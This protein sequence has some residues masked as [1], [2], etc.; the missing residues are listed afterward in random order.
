MTEAIV[1]EDKSFVVH[2]DVEGKFIADLA[3]D[4]VSEGAWVSALSLL[5]ESFEGLTHEEAVAILKGESDLTGWNSDEAGIRIV[6]LG[7]DSEAALTMRERLD[8]LYG[9]VFKHDGTYWKPYATVTSWG[10][11]D[12]YFSLTYGGKRNILDTTSRSNSSRHRPELEHRSLYYAQDPHRDLL[13]VL[14]VLN[15]ECREVLCERVDMPPLWFDVPQRDIADYLA[16]RLKS[17]KLR[18][19][20]EGYVYRE[21]GTEYRTENPTEEQPHPE[22]LPA[23]EET[24]GTVEA[25]ADVRVEAQAA[26]AAQEPALPEPSRGEVLERVRAY[27]QA[28]SLI[29]QFVA[30][31]AAAD[32]PQELSKVSLRFDT[33][34][35]EVDQSLRGGLREFN[36]VRYRLLDEARDAR[37]KKLGD[38]IREQ[39]R[40]QGGFFTL[41][42][43]GPD[44]KPYAPMRS[45]EVPKHPFTLWALRGFDFETFGRE[46]P[47]WKLVCGSGMKQVMDDPYHTDWMLGA[48][49]SLAEYQK[50]EEDGTR[51]E[52]VVM[53]CAFEERHRIVEAHTGFPFSILAKGKATHFSG[54]VEHAEPNQPVKQGCIAIAATAG[55]EFQ[56]AMEA[57]SRPG[58]HGAPGVLICETG[59]KLA[60]LATVGR[61]MGCTVLMVPDARKKYP[62]GSHVFISME[63]G[64]IQ[65][66]I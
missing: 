35:D 38:Q 11:E 40:S 52:H 55:P 25:T 58:E 1:E 62:P 14:P 21:E 8:W 64:T 29:N 53:K 12:Y 19:Q 24:A 41:K 32:T 57:A 13:V 56:L 34:M 60:H 17:K 28:N 18:L 43:K 22:E 36:D 26:P 46:R 15:A 4:R 27:K 50:P 51:L 37:H 30:A 3:R 33:A 10:R 5:R 7:P 42:L 63:E 31:V 23:E 45:I 6:E 48:G 16:S 44:G 9:N 65:L 61:E 49:L 54:E 66:F 2:F 39:A 59:G 47:E 20:Q